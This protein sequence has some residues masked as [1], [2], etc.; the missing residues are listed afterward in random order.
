TVVV[1]HVGVG[2]G[3]RLAPLLR[4]VGDVGLGVLG[5]K[6]VGAAHGDEVTRV[7][8]PAARLAG[9][10]PSISRRPSRARPKVSSSAYSRSPPTGS[11]LAGR[12]TLTPSGLR[13]R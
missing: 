9:A 1:P 13:S 10:H 8:R 4:L 3:A 11:P 12:V 7:S 2:R 5:V 6:E